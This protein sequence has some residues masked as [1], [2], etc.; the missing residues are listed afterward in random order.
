M[1]VSLLAIDISSIV[2]LIF[3]VI[4]I[5]SAIANQSKQNA[6]AP[7]NRGNAA[8]KAGDDAIRD[9]IEAFLNEAKRQKQRGKRTQD[10]EPLEIV[11]IEEPYE[12][13]EIEDFDSPPPQRSARQRRERR[14][15]SREERRQSR[16]E[17]QPQAQSENRQQRSKRK[18]QRISERHVG[19]D[20]LGKGVSQHVESRMHSSLENE[21]LA[22]DVDASVKQHLGE[23]TA[24][25]ESKGKRR[26]GSG[27]QSS[28]AQMLQDKD[29]VRT[30]FILQEILN[31]PL[32]ARESK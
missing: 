1:S 27:V 13:M 10:D 7:G 9:E 2:T 12:V 26:Q 8:G 29:S 5:I 6:Q 17:R 22:H 14:A 15:R 11:E 28:L 32:S 25:S 16:R 4:G 18:R 19:S 24:A 23:F 21:H 3:L 31:R 30:A 20:D